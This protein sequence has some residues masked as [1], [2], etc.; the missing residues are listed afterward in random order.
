MH[1]ESEQLA[2]TM[3]TKPDSVNCSIQASH[4]VWEPERHAK[5]THPTTIQ[6]TFHSASLRKRFQKH[7]VTSQAGTNLNSKINNNDTGLWASKSSASLCFLHLW[8]TKKLMIL[9]G[10][11]IL[12]KF[13]YTFSM[14]WIF[15]LCSSQFQ[16][17]MQLNV[18]MASGRKNIGI[19]LLPA[20]D[21]NRSLINDGYVTTRLHNVTS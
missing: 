21:D 14:S 15:I 17:A 16:G 8:C 20:D 4:T 10:L 5:I 18:Y 11:N 1:K 6:P 7:F 3:R 2:V 12:Y 19:T 13:W 9:G